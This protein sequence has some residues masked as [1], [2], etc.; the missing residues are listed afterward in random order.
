MP[1]I[2][3]KDHHGPIAQR[4]LVYICSPYAGDVEINTLRAQRYC[5]F[6]A[7]LGRLPIAPHLLFPRF[8]DESLPEERALG[9]ECG[10]ALLDR[11]PEIWV[12]GSQISSGM[13][14]EIE[15][16]KRRNLVIRRFD[17]HCEEIS[18]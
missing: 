1:D 18:V 9:I 8:L 2:F 17:I 12:F 11:C 15:K 5:R 7:M 3:P 4:M 6:A 13:A 10:L 14:A 16:A